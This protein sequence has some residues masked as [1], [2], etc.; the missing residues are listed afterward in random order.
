[1]VRTLGYFCA[2][3]PIIE[4]MLK[5]ALK[6]ILDVL[7]SLITTPPILLCAQ[8]FLCVYL[9]Y[10]YQNGG[11]ILSILTNITNCYCPDTINIS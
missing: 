4:K 5:M 9:I 7:E 8:I 2:P 1:M 3:S 11:W 10:C 6:I